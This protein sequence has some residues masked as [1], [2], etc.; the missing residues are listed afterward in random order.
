MIEK[1]KYQDAI[2]LIK[3][4]PT[5]GHS[6]LLVIANDFNAYYVKNTKG[7]HPAYF[8]INEFICHYFLKIWGIATPEIAAVTIDKN[9][10]DVALSQFHKLYFYDNIAFGSKKMEY[11]QEMN[12]LSRIHSK[13]DFNKLKEPMDFLKIALFDIWVENTDRKP[14]NPNLLFQIKDNKLGAVAIDHAFAFD[15]QA[16]INLYKEGVTQSY[17]ENL[18]EHLYVKEIVKHLKMDAAKVEMLNEYYYF[19]IDNTQKHYDEIAQNI[20]EELGFTADIKAALSDFL[21]NSKRNKLVFNEFCS[22]L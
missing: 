2:S 11:A 4:I 17:N 8:L 14:T 16:Y 1:L 19:C 6:P 18:L 7:H 20:P 22:R 9:L 13:S 10:L 21:F 12:E 5:E 3:E 15:S